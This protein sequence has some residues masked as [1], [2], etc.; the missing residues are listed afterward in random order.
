MPGAVHGLKTM[1][2]YKLVINFAELPWVAVTQSGVLVQ[3]PL[4]VTQLMGSAVLKRQ[5][6][7]QG[8]ASASSSDLVACP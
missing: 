8:A 1:D 7:E 4:Y 3:F 6:D 2:D 5:M